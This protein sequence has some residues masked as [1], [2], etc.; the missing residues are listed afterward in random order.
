MSH[1]SLLLMHLSVEDQSRCVDLMGCGTIQVCWAQAGVLSQKYSLHKQ[2][3]WGL[4]ALVNPNL[5]T[6]F[7]EPHTGPSELSLSYQP[8]LSTA[9]YIHHEA[10][11]ACLPA[12][13][14][15]KIIK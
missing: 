6:R 12:C 15:E 1:F 3:E 10:E 13:S 7:T 14:M 4:S 9:G 5:W 8:G 11:P 2:S